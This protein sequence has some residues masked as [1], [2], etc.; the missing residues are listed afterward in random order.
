MVNRCAD[1][2]RDTVEAIR[3]KVADSGLAHFDETGTRVD[4]KTWWV[5]V[6]C[7]SMFTFLYLNRKR[8]TQAMDEG[9][10]LTMFGGIAVHDCWKP[11]W[12]Y[13]DMI[14]AIH[15]RE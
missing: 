3:Q 4:G 1:A 10:V 2:V 13:T 7:N 15:C 8:G 11:Y 5:H 12:N 14:H 9:G 6:A